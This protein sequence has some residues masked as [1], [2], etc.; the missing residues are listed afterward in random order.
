MGE[1]KESLAMREKYWDERTVEERLD[2]L[3]RE[4]IEL[5]EFA[6][7]TAGMTL[8]LRKHRHDQRD[9]VLTLAIEDASVPERARG[10]ARSLRTKAELERRSM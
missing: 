10:A 7:A 6:S 9:G 1:I 5:G 2:V 3:R 8:Q 4:L